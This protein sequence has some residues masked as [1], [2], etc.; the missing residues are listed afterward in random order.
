MENLLKSVV[1]E[2][3]NTLDWVSH[4][5][6]FV[7]LLGKLV[8]PL[9]S[10]SSWKVTNLNFFGCGSDESVGGLLQSLNEWAF[11]SFL[12]K[13][14]HGTSDVSFEALLVSDIE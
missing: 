7:K 11:L 2:V 13:F 1:N 4:L 5:H 6:D 14:P 10:L 9:H 3:F 12:L 8:D